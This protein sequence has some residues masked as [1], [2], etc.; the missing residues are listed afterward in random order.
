MGDNPRPANMYT[1][2]LSV[3]LFSLG[4]SSLGWVTM[5]WQKSAHQQQRQVRLDAEHARL[6]AIEQAGKEK[7]A[8]QAADQLAWVVKTR[9][10]CSRRAAQNAGI[11]YQQKMASAG[12][13]ASPSIFMK[14]DYDTAYEACLHESGVE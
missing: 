11:T 4:L 10:E 13:P 6:V 14:V 5:Q 9:Q 3:G 7:D 12:L 1:L 2:L 8:Q